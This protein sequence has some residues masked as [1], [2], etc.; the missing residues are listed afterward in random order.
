[1]KDIS[2]MGKYPHFILKQYKYKNM[3]WNIIENSTQVSGGIDIVFNPENNVLRFSILQYKLD[4]LPELIIRSVDSRS[5][6]I[7]F[8]QIR[9]FSDM[10]SDD[11]ILA[12]NISGREMITGEIMLIHDAWGGIIISEMIFDKILFD[13]CTIILAITHNKTDEWKTKMTDALHK[14]NFKIEN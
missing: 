12:K 7:E 5:T 14:L 6:G 4:D 13:Y 3:N 11:K 1:M 2:K 10:D 8:V 9:N